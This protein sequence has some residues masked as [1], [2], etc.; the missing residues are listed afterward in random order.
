MPSNNVSLEGFTFFPNVVSR[1]ARLMPRK[2]QTSLLGLEDSSSLVD[3]TFEQYVPRICV[4]DEFFRVFQTEAAYS[5]AQRDSGLDFCDLLKIIFS[6]RGDHVADIQKQLAS[7]LLHSLTSN[8]RLEGLDQVHPKTSTSKLN[9]CHQMLSHL[10]QVELFCLDPLP[11][12]QA[13]VFDQFIPDSDDVEEPIVSRGLR[14]SVAMCSNSRLVNPMKD[15]FENM[16]QRRIQQCDHIIKRF[17]PSEQSPCAE[18][19]S[20]STSDTDASVG[21]SKPNLTILR[22]A[23]QEGAPTALETVEEEQSDVEEDVG[24]TVEDEP[25]AEI[26]TVPDKVQDVRYDDEAC[27][28]TA[29]NCINLNDAADPGTDFSPEHPDGYWDLPPLPPTPDSALNKDFQS[30][31]PPIPSTPQAMIEPRFDTTAE[32][33]EDDCERD[34]ADSRTSPE[35]TTSSTGNAGPS[36]VVEGASPVVSPVICLE[37]SVAGEAGQ[38]ADVGDSLTPLTVKTRSRATAGMHPSTPSPRE[39]NVSMWN[40]QFANLDFSRGPPGTCMR[41]PRS[42]SAV[43]RTPSTSALSRAPPA[44]ST[45]LSS[46]VSRKDVALPPPP[47]LD[48][49]LIP[50]RRRPTRNHP[51]VERWSHISST[52]TAIYKT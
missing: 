10:S 38:D 51:S 31:L 52:G 14:P 3:I 7:Q 17:F 45:P 18:C 5:D 35:S 44:A 30:S 1:P 34:T 13:A 12:H 33:C 27:G 47:T 29:V 48:R 11:S 43:S 15:R 40:R 4:R 39:S 22:E 6:N 36:S 26:E 19:P 21:D 50:K 9:Q 2:A 46:R 32:C 37:E 16:I 25:Q 49:P 8:Q 20:P 28:A 23:R 24:E 41:P 42:R